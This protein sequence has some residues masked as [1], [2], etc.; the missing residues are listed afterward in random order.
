MHAQTTNDLKY[1]L[2]TSLHI[3][4]LVF[5]VMFVI[6]WKMSGPAHHVIVVACI[7]LVARSVF[8]F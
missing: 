8:F 4:A 6:L 5:Y 7:L 2:S 3:E 1:L